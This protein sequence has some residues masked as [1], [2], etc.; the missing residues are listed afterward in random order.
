MFS[1][2]DFKMKQITR[3][4]LRVCILLLL[5]LVSIDSQPHTMSKSCVLLDPDFEG[6]EPIFDETGM[7]VIDSIQHD[8]LHENFIEFVVD[9]CNG[10][11]IYVQ[12]RWS[13]GNKLLP[14]KG[15]ITLS[16]RIITYVAE[17]YGHKLKLYTLPIEASS[18]YEVE[19]HDMTIRVESYH[20][21]WVYT[22]VM[23]ENSEKVSGWI[24]PQDQCP[25]VYTTCN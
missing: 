24:S 1:F 22:T 11:K 12:P 7:V 4:L 19:C 18:F 20:K 21:G 8:F 16:E 13:F 17:C 25:N 5:C 6:K 2:K 9:T 14:I 3:I 23:D 15:W 10:N